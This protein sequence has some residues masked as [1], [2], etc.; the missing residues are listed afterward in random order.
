MS[1]IYLKSSDDQPFSM[2][3]AA[4][5]LSL[6]LKRIIE[7]KDRVNYFIRIDNVK[8]IILTKVID[9][10]HNHII[11]KDD[12][13]VLKLFDQ[14]FVRNVDEVSMM[15]LMDAAKNLEIESLYELCY[16]A[17][18]DKLKAKKLHEIEEMFYKEDLDQVAGICLETVLSSL[19]LRK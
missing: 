11:S 15:Y 10:C 19:D 9:Y 4:V 6:K 13:E 12:T 5:K 18:I 7:V 3:E 1:T 16:P 8:G 17:L 2:E 14:E